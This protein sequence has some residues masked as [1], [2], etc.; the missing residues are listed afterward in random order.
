M[1]PLA[2]Y[3]YIIQISVWWRQLTVTL[4]ILLNFLFKQF[5]NFKNGKH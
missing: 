2:G 5:H 3:C 1:K 4:Y